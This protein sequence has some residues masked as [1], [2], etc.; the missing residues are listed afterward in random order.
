MHPARSRF[1]CLAMLLTA[2]CSRPDP[3]PAASSAASAAPVP[4]V[5]PSWRAE[6]AAIQRQIAAGIAEQPTRV[7]EVAVVGKPGD[8]RQPRFRITNRGSR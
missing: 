2:M 4:A 3:Q 5:D 1:P 7:T 8:R 6:A